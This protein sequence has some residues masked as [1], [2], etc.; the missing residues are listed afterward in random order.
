MTHEKHYFID[1]KYS[2]GV[3]QWGAGTNKLWFIYPNG[4]PKHWI[5]SGESHG[6]FAKVHNAGIREWK[7]FNFT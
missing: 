7:R 2:I 1:H 3:K 4:Q 5:M 6:S